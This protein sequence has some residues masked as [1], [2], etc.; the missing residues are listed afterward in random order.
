M[1]FLALLLLIALVVLLFTPILPLRRRRA[2]VANFPFVTLGLLAINSVIFF[3]N[4]SPTEGLVISERVV[5]GWGLMRGHLQFLPL[6]SYAFVHSDLFHLL[7]NMITLYVIG[8]HLEEALG[9]LA[10]LVAYLTGALV[11]GLAHV[12]ITN[13]FF[14]VAAPEESLIGA[15]GAIFAVLGLFAVRFWR[16]RVRLFGVPAVPA[17]I[18]V[19]IVMALQIFLAIRSLV[20]PGADQVAYTAHLAGF[21]FGLGI[22]FPLRVLEQSAREYGIEDAEAALA[23]G[24][25]PTAARYYRELLVRTP[26]DGGLAHTLALVQLRLGDQ[27]VAHR[28]FTEALDLFSKQGNAAAVARVYSDAQR[29]LLCVSLPVRLLQRVA[30]ACE[31]AQQYELTRHALA[32]LCRDFPH[33]QDAEL[34]MLKLGKLHLQKLHQRDNA[35]AIFAEFLRLYPTSEWANHVRGMITEN[36]NAS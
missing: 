27:E 24:D 15:S 11:A 18:A 22:A 10:Y 23:Q 17:A 19:S 26:T 4:L 30:S 3:G 6:I 14:P 33:T 32:N 16:T 13:A 20:T 5:Q 9:N 25:L 21:F 34:G 28:Y 35:L 12:L 2:G 8:V 31:D 29:N 1:L 36:Q 7:G